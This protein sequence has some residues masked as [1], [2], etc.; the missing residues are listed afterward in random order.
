MNAERARLGLPAVSYVTQH[1]PEPPKV[2]RVRPVSTKRTKVRS[3]FRAIVLRKLPTYEFTA[4]ST[5]DI[6]ASCGVSRQKILDCL[7]ELRDDGIAALI[8]PSESFKR[9]LLWYRINMQGRV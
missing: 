4:A 7:Y 5:S 1:A 3:E 6:A 2:N 8:E 9:G